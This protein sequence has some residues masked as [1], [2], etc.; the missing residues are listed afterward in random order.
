MK[1]LFIAFAL[2]LCQCGMAQQTVS[3]GKLIEYPD[4]SSSI[5]TSRDVF[6]WLPSDYSPKEKYYFCLSCLSIPPKMLIFN[7][8]LPC[9]LDI[10][11]CV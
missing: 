7:C 8:F 9:S 3:L 6:V 2:L 5:V 10:E 1:F 4:F 11:I